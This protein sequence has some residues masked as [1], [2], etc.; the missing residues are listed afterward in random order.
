MLLLRPVMKSDRAIELRSVAGEMESVTTRK[1]TVTGFVFC[2]LLPAGKLED[3]SRSLRRRACVAELQFCP[4][5]SHTSVISTDPAVVGIDSS[6]ETSMTACAWLP[7]SDG[8]F[9]MPSTTTNELTA[10]VPKTGGTSKNET[11]SSH[12]SSRWAWMALIDG[13][14][15]SEKPLTSLRRPPN[16]TLQCCAS[17][18]EQL[19][20][21]P[22][23][24]VVGWTRLTM[25]IFVSSLRTVTLSASVPARGKG[26]AVDHASERHFQQRCALLKDRT[27]F[28]PHQGQTIR[29]QSEY[30]Q[31][32]RT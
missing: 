22:V 7:N 5:A 2:R 8:S 27:E 16:A 3:S 21:P 6:S 32:L 31:R 10:S 18:P 26:G 29:G 14:G 13:V 28:S 9:T 11:G 30:H 23:H 4:F 19:I 24:V 17:R 25:L 1:L 12:R 20:D 15:G